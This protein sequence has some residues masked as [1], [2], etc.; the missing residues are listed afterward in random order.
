MLPDASEVQC[1]L[2]HL[3][4]AAARLGG[5]GGAGEAE[6][7]RHGRLA[8]GSGHRIL[9]SGAEMQHLSTA[10]PGA[11][12]RTVTVAE[13]LAFDLPA[14]SPKQNVPEEHTHTSWLR[15]LV[16]QGADELYAANRAEAEERRRRNWP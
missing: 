13:G 3:G 1:P 10:T 8:A 15:E 11:V 2:R 5:S 4:G 6:P 7:G 14:A 12:S 9:R 16:R